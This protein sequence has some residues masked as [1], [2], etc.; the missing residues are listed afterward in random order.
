[1]KDLPTPPARF[2]FTNRAVYLATLSTLC[3]FL[4]L[5]L[6]RAYPY[7][8][9]VSL[10]TS[11]GNDWLTYKQNAL[12]ILRGGLSMPC[13]ERGYHLPGGFLYNY[14]LAAVFALFGEN[15]SYVYLIHASMLACTVGLPTLAFK[16]YLT[17][18]ATL[19]YFTGLLFV[20]LFDVYIF[21]TFR[22][23][24]ENLVLLLLS[25]FYLLVL[26]TF[27][28]RSLLLAALAGAMLGLCVLCRQNLILLAPSTAALLFV[29]LK[30]R[31]RRALISATYALSF[32]L[33][34]SLLPLRNYAATGEPSIPLIRHG[35]RDFASSL[36]PAEPLTPAS[37]REKMP[38]ALDFYAR[39]IL[40]CAG[41]TTSLGLPLYWL[42][43]HWTLMWIGALVYALRLLRRR[44]VEFW[45]GFAFTFLL[46]YLAPLI[47]VG[48]VHNYGV[49]MVLPVVPVLLLLA[50]SALNRSDS[51][52]RLSEAAVPRAA[53]D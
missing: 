2:T 12:C 32:C 3:F 30:R 5:S 53:H 8:D 48:D 9:D 37:V 51:C 31:P 11:A 16:P 42:K 18:K 39:R 21:Y 46:M 28:R 27:E 7:L 14:F 38:A 25:L 40:F 17:P 20:A 36:T 52:E 50:V 44:R 22:L 43:P 23:L 41:L 29:Y 4:L 47:A 1:M 49:R 26:R 24:S 34:F 13:V 6:Y 15:S 33:V 19:I 45:E 35:V 10:A